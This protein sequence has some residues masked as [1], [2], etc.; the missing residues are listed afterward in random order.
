MATTARRAQNVI[1]LFI[2]IGIFYS[3]AY[4]QNQPKGKFCEEYEIKDYGACITLK[5]DNTF[6]HSFGGDM[7]TE[8][9]GKGEYNFI[10]NKLILNYNKTEPV[11]TGYHLSKIWT[12][13]KNTITVNFKFFDFDS[14]PVPNVNVFYKDS[15]SKQGYGGGVASEKGVLSLNLKKDKTF[16]K[17]KMTNIGYSPYELSIDKNYNYVISVYLQKV[18]KGLPILNQ[19]DT[20]IIHKKRPKYFTVRNKN[21]SI[22]T[23]KKSEN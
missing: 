2:Y 15:L 10:D 21:G 3:N 5:P 1:K 23:W 17:L 18:G 14:I 22:T 4:A 19:I 6:V 9:H 12:N 8:A 11:K 13:N 7:G 20:L 16:L